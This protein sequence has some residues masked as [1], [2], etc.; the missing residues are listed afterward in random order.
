MPNVESKMLIDTNIV[1]AAEDYSSPHGHVDGAAASRLLRLAQELAFTV[2][3]SSGT[4][5]DISRAHQ[6]R[7]EVRTRQL[8]RYYVL[9]PIPIDHA[10]AR[11]AHFPADPGPNDAADLEVLCALAAGAADFLVTQDARLR[12]RAARVVANERVLSLAEATEWLESLQSQPSSIPSVS[13]AKGYSIALGAPVFDSLRLTYPGFDEWWRRKVA[14]EPRHVAVIGDPWDPLG[15]AVFK[16]EIDGPQGPTLK[17]CTFKVRSDQ[18]GSKLGEQ[19]LKGSLDYARRN[20]HNSVYM[21]VNPASE[22]VAWL[23]DFGFSWTSIVRQNGDQV[24]LKDLKPPTGLGA[25]TPLDHAV[26]YGPGEA[27]VDRAF[28]VPIQRQWH[29]I[30]F[31]EVPDAQLQLIPEADRPCGNAIRKAYLSHSRTNRLQAGDFL[32]FLRTGDGPSEVTVTGVVESVLRSPDP[33]EII[34][35]VGSRTVYSKADIASRCERGP[36][37]AIRFRLD[38]V[39]DRTTTSR[40]LI[41]QGLLKG[42]PQSIT[43]LSTEGVEWARQLS[44]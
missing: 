34:E 18:G 42:A 11:R 20:G 40:D 19:L 23:G 13:I 8:E 4:Q 21:E 2:C 29:E 9:G 26:T 12:A 33:V 24:L 1:I 22:L 28:M 36:V 41:A 5:S 27:I 10:V 25:L 16:P 30:L 44:E 35:F 14:H 7:R 3:V 39:L 38:R 31:P 32:A 6:E 43:Q 15:I 17:I 37:L